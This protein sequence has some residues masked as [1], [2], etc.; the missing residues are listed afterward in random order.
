MSSNTISLTPKRGVTLGLLNCGMP[1]DTL[2]V[3]PFQLDE[4]LIPI[5]YEVEGQAPKRVGV[6][7]QLEMYGDLKAK[8]FHKPYI[9]CI[10]SNPNDARAKLYAAHLLQRA[11][12]YHNKGLTPSYLRGRNPPR[13]H[14]LNGSYRDALRDDP[15][16]KP[17][18]LILSNITP[19]STSQK[20]EKLRDLLEQHSSVPRIVVVA[21]CDPVKFCNEILYIQAH[22]CAHFSATRR[23]SV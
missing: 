4:H 3:R 7:R 19:T 5:T 10:G 20:I 18:M 9:Y 17:N 23:T 1:R 12:L 15:D 21:G 11:Y 2:K 6:Q 8:P 16:I 22:Y 14:V 13:W